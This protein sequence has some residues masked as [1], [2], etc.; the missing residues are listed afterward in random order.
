MWED[1]SPAEA[2]LAGTKDGDFVLLLSHR[3]YEY[4]SYAALGADLI[5]SGHVHGGLIRLPGIG[6]LVGPGREFL[7]KYSGGGYSGADRSSL[8]VSRGLAG[9]K[10]NKSSFHWPRLFNPREVVVITLKKG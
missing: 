2:L 9:V 6:G 7:P 8:V 3:P 1:R 10:F 5:V 4:E